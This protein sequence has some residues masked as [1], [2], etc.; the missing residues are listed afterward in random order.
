MVKT[1]SKA[2]IKFTGLMGQNFVAISFGSPGAPQGGGRHGAGQTEEQPDLNAVMAKLDGAAGRHPEHDQ[3][4]SERQNQQFVRPAG[5]F[6]QT[7]QRQH[8]R[9][10][11]SNIDNIT[12][13][14]AAG[15]G[16]VG[17]LIY[18]DDAL[19]LRADNG[20][21]FAGD[22]RDADAMIASSI[23]SSP[24]SPTARAPSAN[25]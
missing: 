17:K 6:R 20:D 1:D 22:R 19:H 8:R 23:S 14:I 11:I 24:T 10:R 18:E 25:W 21:Q 13:Q 12:G 2:S 16:T 7:K 15:Q 3:G 5:G 9:R 4:F